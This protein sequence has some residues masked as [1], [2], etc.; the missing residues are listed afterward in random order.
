MND[1]KPKMTKIFQRSDQFKGA[2]KL[3]VAYNFPVS[4]MLHCEHDRVQGLL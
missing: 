3:G 2:I 1:L 4:R